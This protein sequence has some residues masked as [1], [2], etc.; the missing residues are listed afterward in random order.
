AVVDDDQRPAFE[1]DALA[2]LQ[3][4]LPA[5]LDLRELPLGQARD[6]GPGEPRHVYDILVGDDLRLAA[7]D[8]GSRRQLRLE[9]HAYLAHEQQTQ[10]RAELA[11]DLD[12]YGYAA[13]RERQHHRIGEAPA[14]EH[15]R[16][17]PSRGAAV[18]EERAFHRTGQSHGPTSR[19]I[20]G[21]PP[22][23]DGTCTGW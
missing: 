23:W 6:V 8:H 16:E 3:V 22:P 5:T 17:R 2:A 11:R 4:D 15:V 14:R 1:S 10:R 9:R 18:G 20:S 13:A 19:A 21:A 12:R 7:V